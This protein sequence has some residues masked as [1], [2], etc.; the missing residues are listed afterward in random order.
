MGSA[1]PPPVPTHP[2]PAPAAPPPPPAEPLTPPAAGDAEELPVVEADEVLVD[3]PAVGLAAEVAT[4]NPDLVKDT[5][6]ATEEAGGK[7]S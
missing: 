2:A 3:D 1:A 7:Q 5:A 6:E 4:S